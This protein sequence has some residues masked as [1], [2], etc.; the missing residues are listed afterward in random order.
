[1]T[2]LP[3]GNGSAEQAMRTT[4]FDRADGNGLVVHDEQVIHFDSP[5]A[6]CLLHFRFSN[7]EKT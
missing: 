5:P 3:L 6:D 4:S 1:M 7:D 2:E